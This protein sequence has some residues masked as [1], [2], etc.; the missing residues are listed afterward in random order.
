M[1][2]PLGPGLRRRQTWQL[3]SEIAR[4]LTPSLTGEGAYVFITGRRQSELDDAVR[5]RGAGRLQRGRPPPGH[6]HVASLDH[7]LRTG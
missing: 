1:E 4:Q 2:A 7:G 6:S 5:E 3:N